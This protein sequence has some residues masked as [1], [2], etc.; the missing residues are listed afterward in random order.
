MQ[1]ARVGAALFLA[2]AARAFAQSE[3]IAEFKGTINAGQGRMIQT[4]GKVYF[5]KAVAYRS[6]WETDMS[7]LMKGRNMLQGAFPTRHKTIAI[8]KLSD[9]DKV[10]TLDEQRKSYMITDLKS[11]RGEGAPDASSKIFT[12]KKLGRDTVGGLACEK[13][14]V[15]SSDGTR[16]EL[17]VAT[18]FTPS[19]AWVEATGRREG[20][21]DLIKALKDA[22][23][24]GFPIRTAIHSR[25][26]SQAAYTLELVRLETRPVPASVFEVSPDFVDAKSAREEMMRRSRGR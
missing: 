4:S 11:L 5:V 2:L 25:G 13:A 9:P 8:Q 7:A 18:D 17:C 14:L 16:S 3:G 1:S 26:E 6:E 22:G 15:T 24:D 23:L 12:V 21:N 20:S 19:S 10:V